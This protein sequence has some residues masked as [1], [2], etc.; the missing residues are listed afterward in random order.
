M[1]I[2]SYLH[3]GLVAELV[4]GGDLPTAHDP[5]IACVP[6]V[7]SVPLRLHRSATE[8]VRGR[9]AHLLEY[10]FFL[11]SFRDV[12]SIEGVPGKR[13]RIGKINKL[14]GVGAVENRPSNTKSEEKK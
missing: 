2:F 14:D 10:Y 8:E 5:C 3:K 7:A 11:G 13:F 6:C 1:P 4:L 12:A 9:G